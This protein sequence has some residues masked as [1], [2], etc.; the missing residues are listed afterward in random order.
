MDRNIGRSGRIIKATSRI[1]RCFPAG[2]AYQLT[3]APRWYLARNRIFWQDR[4]PLT[5]VSTPL[6]RIN[7]LFEQV[8]VLNL[9]RRP[10]RMAAVAAQLH[11]LEVTFRR[12]PAIDGRDPDVASTWHTYAAGN[13][14]RVAPGTRPVRT[15][16]EFYLDYESERA[17][18]AFVEGRE[19]RKAI[20][21]PGAWGLLKSMTALVEEALASSWE[22]ILILEDDVLFHRD[23]LMLFDRF[24]RQVAHD[25]QVLQLGAMQLHWEPDWIDWYSA[26]LYRCHGSSIGAHA[27][28]LRRATLPILLERCRACELPFDIGPLHAVKRCFAQSCFT[29]FPNLAIQDATDSEIGLSRLFFSEARKTKNLYRWNLPDYGLGALPARA[30]NGG[31]AATDMSGHDGLQAKQERTFSF[32]T[33]PGRVRVLAARFGFGSLGRRWNGATDPAVPSAVGPPSVAKTPELPPPLQL[34]DDHHPG[35]RTIAV[36]VYGMDTLE[37]AG[38]LDVVDRH[39]KA[40][41]LTPIFLTDHDGFDLFRAHGRVFEYLPPPQAREKFA[42]DLNWDLY[43]LRRLALIRRKWQP[44]RVIAFGRTAAEVVQLWLES[45][46]EQTPVPALLKGR[47][48]GGELEWGAAREAEVMQR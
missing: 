4:L 36:L 13:L 7:D 20:A 3:S 33:V 41:D 42:P 31:G 24:T 29:M 35:R 12:F 28:G 23:T 43:V 6:H 15:Y 40:R 46:F 26:N 9:D 17:R 22:S 8:V 30:V 27:V 14:V 45:P 2:K 32:T 44:A 19:G 18:V 10:D 21:S 38:A 39:C 25:W 34:H 16:R 48:E 37:L 1:R 11:N 47:S 5:R